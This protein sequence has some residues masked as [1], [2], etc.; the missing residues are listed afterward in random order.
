M[1][2]VLARSTPRI[3]AA[4]RRTD[5]RIAARDLPWLLGAR[6]AGGPIVSVINLSLRGALFE[7]PQLLRPGDPADFE[8]DADG[9]RTRSSSIIVR[10]EIAELRADA[11]RYRGACAFA[12][13]LPWTE[14]L[15]V[16]SS[17][18]QDVRL[19]TAVYD[20]WAGWSECAVLLRHGRRRLA[21]FMQAFQPWSG[22]LTLCASPRPAE[23]RRDIVPLSLVRAVIVSRDVMGVDAPAASAL[24]PPDSRA[25]EVVFR[26]NQRL[27]G[28]I[29]AFSADEPGFWILPAAADRWTRVFAVAE[30]V[31]EIRV[32][33]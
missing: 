11:V 17:G 33:V 13:P 9:E 26:N 2:F 5:V 18:D 20:P 19:P 29:P 6:M 30:A 24:P 3:V 14:R 31:A 12:D 22:A 1:P 23:S 25:V 4:N 32:Y 16:R 21:G 10:S 28:T 7:I 8:I 27:H 15:T